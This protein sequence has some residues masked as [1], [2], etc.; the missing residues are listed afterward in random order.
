MQPSDI[1][2]PEY[3]RPQF[4]RGDWI[5][6]NGPWSYTFDF[7]ESGMAHARA[8]KQ[9]TGF[10]SS[11]L[12]PFCPE[13]TL[14]GVGHTDFIPAMWYHRKIEIPDTWG[15]KR[16]LLHFGGADYECEA[17]V[18]GVSVGTH[19][20]GTVS[21]S[22]DIT[23]VAAAGTTHDL[24]VRIKDDIRDNHQPH[25]KQS[26]SFASHGC[27]YTRT[28]GIWQTVW[29]EAVDPCGL[30]DVQITPDIDGGT[31]TVVPRYWGTVRGG[32][33]I[34]EARAG[35][36]VLSRTEVPAA[37]GV[38][39]VLAIDDAMLWSPENPFLYDIMLKVVDADGAVIDEVSSY[40]GLRKVHIE[41][42]RVYLNNEPIYQ[43]LVLDQGFYPD[44]IW[45]APS[46]AALKNDIELSMKAGFNGARLH[47]K[48]FEE[49]FH[50]WADK[51][52][53]LTWAESASW[54]CDCN[55][56]LSARNFLSEW[57]EIVVRDRNH[58]SIITWTPFNETH[59]YTQ[60]QVHRRLH[61]DCYDLCKDLDP[62]RP[63]NDASGYL[64]HIT[65]LWTVHAYDQDPEK[66]LEKL[67]PTEEG[68]V[69]RNVPKHE[70]A[71]GGQPYLV[72][73]YGGIK[74]IPEERREDDADSWGYGD[75][76]RSLDEFY[77]RLEA[78]TDVLLG[79]DHISGYC[80]TQLTDVE[81]EQNGI[82]NYDR[83][84]KF[85]MARVCKVFSKEPK[86]LAE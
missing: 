15:Q 79:L 85:D 23:K 32:R 56:E 37:G 46:D 70:P 53:Y 6:L 57:K 69:Y 9:S 59:E 1:P 71:Y 34:V 74:W 3:P 44:G 29:L 4:E 43:R 63:V 55:A 39:A 40:C 58:P 54:G 77:V 21:F 84:E 66:L 64:H 68:G 20:G 16:V 81:Q 45:T 28:T 12:V 42:N 78:L 73:E 38:P 67:T 51:L 72:D 80:Y 49:R 22:F 5:N 41:G 48:V 62:T 61:L 2:R 24:V 7:G 10:D 8:L 27:S 31:F 83:T 65:D 82:Y 13:S 86:G 36:K 11:I 25:G 19:F 18:D 33:L 52:G 14:S 47:Q 35:D 75:T 30:Q 50:Y 17:F 26:A 60:P 76:P